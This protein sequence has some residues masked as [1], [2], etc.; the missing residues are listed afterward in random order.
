MTANSSFFVCFFVEASERGF[1]LK[2]PIHFN[3]TQLAFHHSTRKPSVNFPTTLWY[4]RISGLVLPRSQGF[5]LKI[6]MRGGG[7]GKR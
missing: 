4:C 6:F 5:Y 1:F 3:E 2:A 7:K